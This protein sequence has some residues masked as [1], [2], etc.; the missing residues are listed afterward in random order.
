[1]DRN[2]VGFVICKQSKPTGILPYSM[3]TTS[4]AHRLLVVSIIFFL[5]D[6]FLSKKTTLPGL[7]NN[8]H[9][10]THQRPKTYSLEY[11]KTKEKTRT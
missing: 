4:T 2:I 1:M 10:T 11:Y 9:S 8:N 5:I 6:S 3:L 7:Y